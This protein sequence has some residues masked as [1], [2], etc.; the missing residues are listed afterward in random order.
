MGRVARSMDK[1]KSRQNQRKE[2]KDD[3]L[4]ASMQSGMRRSACPRLW[5]RCQDGWGEMSATS[6]TSATSSYVLYLLRSSTM[7]P[8]VSTPARPRCVPVQ[9]SLG[10]GHSELTPQ[11]S[12]AAQDDTPGNTRQTHHS[13][14]HLST[15]NRE[16]GTFFCRQSCLTFL[17]KKQDDFSFSLENQRST[18]LTLTSSDTRS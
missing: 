13:P 2:E 17:L 7:V 15:G 10:P 12:K 8:N 16:Q 1:S 14:T 11:M 5:R 4:T 18:I 6:A 3:E 9:I